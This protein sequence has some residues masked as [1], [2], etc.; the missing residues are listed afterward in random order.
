MLVNQVAASVRDCSCH[1]FHCLKE[2]KHGR[3]ICFIFPQV[4]F[5]TSA[6]P[7]LLTLSSQRCALRDRA[8]LPV[9]SPC[10]MQESFCNYQRTPYARI[11]LFQSNPLILRRGSKAFFGIFSSKKQ[12]VSPRCPRSQY[13]FSWN[14]DFA[15]SSQSGVIS[16]YAKWKAD[17]LFSE[18]I[19]GL[20]SSKKPHASS[21]S[22]HSSEHMRFRSAIVSGYS[23][24]HGAIMRSPSVSRM[25]FSSAVVIGYRRK[26]WRTD[27]VR[28]LSA[29]RGLFMP[30]K[31]AP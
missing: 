14:L 31:V 24:M 9:I 8:V 28:V 23:P 13:A 26:H 29:F 25:L 17:Q 20:F 16:R 22:K 30:E 4:G 1:H 18:A 6:C 2:L 21:T 19:F 3:L 12:Q 15:L 11:R 7:F 27:T 5:V 10:I